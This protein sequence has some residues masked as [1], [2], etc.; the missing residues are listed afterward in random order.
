MLN[1]IKDSVDAQLRDQQ[2]EFRTDR[3]CTDQIATLRMI[4][5]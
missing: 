3:S 1:R 4:V 2:A 5:E